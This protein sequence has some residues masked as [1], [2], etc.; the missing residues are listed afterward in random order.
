MTRERPGGTEGV[1]DLGPARDRK[2]SLTRG[3]GLPAG[4]PD[5]RTLV[6]LSMPDGSG[7]LAVDGERLLG[8][9]VGFARALR[10][11]GLRV[12]LGAVVDFARALALVPIGD[13][14]LVRAA[15][16]ALFVRRHDDLAVYERVFR[17]FWRARRGAAPQMEAPSALRRRSDEDRPDAAS[18]PATAPRTRRMAGSWRH[19]GDVGSGDDDGDAFDGL[20]VSARAYSHQQVDRRLSFDRMTAAELRE[21]ERCIDLLAPRMELRRTRRRELHARG[22]VLAPRAMLRRNLKTGGDPVEWVWQRRVRRP[23][24]LVV[25]CDVS[26]SMERHSRLLLRFSQALATSAVRTEAFVFGTRLTRVTRLLSDRDRDRALERVVDATTDWSGGTRIGECLREFNRRWGRRVLR[27]SAIVVVVSDGWDRGDPALVREEA[28]RLQR[29]C[30]RL[31]WLNPLASAPGYEPLAAG[32]SAALPY[33]DDFVPAG[34]L[35]SLE[36]LAALLADAAARRRNVRRSYAAGEA[37]GAAVPVPGPP[38][39][40]GRQGALGRA[41][42]SGAAW[43]EVTGRVGSVTAAGADTGGRVA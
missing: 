42:T 30:H 36:R 38:G 6:A 35:A 24:Q 37:A 25:L 34:T 5:G 27:S 18:S 39:S 32:M 7:A 41:P 1:D 19:L 9:A 31:I 43:S 11:A 15:G 4:R 8:E 22:R 13:R 21:A 26:G 17:R 28:A 20:A 10:A 23:R 16:A 12:D 40:Q 33:V 29:G 3:P 2:R 14:E